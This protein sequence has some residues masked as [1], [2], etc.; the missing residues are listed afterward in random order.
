MT[1]RIRALFFIVLGFLLVWF[2]YI[3]R[4]ILTPFILAAIFAYI[5]NPVVD[6]FYHRIKLPRTITI[7]VIYF[8]IMGL[9]VGL[10]VLLT[11]RV[12]LE[13]SELT[14]YVNN[15][16]K[17]ARAQINTLPDFVQPIV[18]ETLTSLEKSKIFTSDALFILFPKAISRI[19]SIFIFLFSAFY[20]LKEGRSI[21]KKILGFIPDNSKKD[22]EILLN[23]MNRIFSGY[24]RGQLILVFLVSLIL[25]MALSIIGVKFALILAIF[26]GFAEIVPIIGPITAGGVASLVVLVTGQANFSLNPVQAAIIV[27]AVYFFVRQFQDYFVTPYVMGRIVKLHPLLILFSVLAGGHIAGILGFILAVPIAASLKLVLEFLIEKINER[28]N[29]KKASGR[30]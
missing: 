20:F 3:E 11:R 14:A 18:V 25:F 27:A 13:S 24:L 4:A 5:F 1:I 8:L 15:L 30:K 21:L 10:G 2:L 22:I 6:F 17:T 23:R 26:S 29:V 19:I 16:V 9:I 7:I 12:V 28:D